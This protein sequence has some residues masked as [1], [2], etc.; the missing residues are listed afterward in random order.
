[1]KLATGRSARDIPSEYSFPEFLYKRFQ[2]QI[3]NCAADCT[4]R[5]LKYIFP[6]KTNDKVQTNIKLTVPYTNLCCI[7][8]LN[9]VCSKGLSSPFNANCACACYWNNTEAQLSVFT[10]LLK[11]RWYETAVSKVV[12][13]SGFPIVVFPSLGGRL[14][15]FG[16]SFLH[17]PFEY[18]SFPRKNKQL[19]RK[20]LNVIPL[21]NGRLSRHSCICNNHFVEKDY[22]YVEGKRFLKR[23][24]FPTRNI[25]KMA[26]LV[27]RL[28]KSKLDKSHSVSLTTKHFVYL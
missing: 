13:P 19:N 8:L 6:N 5:Y 11:G 14:Y 15:R 23:N 18:S 28:N 1:M 17:L 25:C 20:W 3:K 26:K 9:Q 7:K 27:S 4:L 21:R 12:K 2:T 10:N 22:E 24:V 16:C